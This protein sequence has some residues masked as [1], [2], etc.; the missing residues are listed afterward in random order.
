MPASLKYKLT[1]F[2]LKGRMDELGFYVPSTVF[3][4]FETMEGWT[5]KA[6]C[7]EAPFRFGKNLASSGI[8]TRDPVIR[9]RER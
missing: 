7:N 6:L 4:H 5:W 2:N 3:S 9:S 8:R 1:Y